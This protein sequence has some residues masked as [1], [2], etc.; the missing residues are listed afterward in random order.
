MKAPANEGAASRTKSVR[1][2]PRM[3]STAA[4]SLAERLIGSLR[5]H[6]AVAQSP[7]GEA[8]ERPLDGPLCRELHSGRMV[9]EF[10][11]VIVGRIDADALRTRGGLSKPFPARLDLL[12]PHSRSGFRLRHGFRLL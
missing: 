9:D 6:G 3:T 4:A 5:S 7:L 1:V 8:I 11:H 12:L 10:A 2:P